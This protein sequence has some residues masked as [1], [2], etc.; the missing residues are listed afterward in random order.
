MFALYDSLLL[1]LVFS[2]AYCKTQREMRF[3]IFSG[4]NLNSRIVMRPRYIAIAYI[5]FVYNFFEYLRHL[6]LRF[7]RFQ[8]KSRDRTNGI[9]ETFISNFYFS[10]EYSFSENK[11]L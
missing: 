10:I 9:S 6:Q 2:H 8:L 5:Y 3:F 11:Y 7:S 1:Q 4:K